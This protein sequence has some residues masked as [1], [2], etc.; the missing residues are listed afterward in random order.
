M[1][2]I[3]SV[4]NHNSLG[5]NSAYLCFYATSADPFG[6][7]PPQGHREEEIRYTESQGNSCYLPLSALPWH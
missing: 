1:P 6:S 5:G 2:F 4:A 3:I 7:A